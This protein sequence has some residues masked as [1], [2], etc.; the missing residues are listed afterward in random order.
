MMAMDHHRPPY[1][2]TEHD[3]PEPE[4]C[5]LCGSNGPTRTGLCWTEGRG[6]FA[7]PRCLDVTACRTKRGLP[8]EP[9]RPRQ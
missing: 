9:A 6:F 1:W 5:A 3:R 2:E 4:A 7:G 8:P